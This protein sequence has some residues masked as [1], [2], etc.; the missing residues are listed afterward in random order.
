[1][2]KILFVGHLGPKITGAVAMN[3]EF[4]NAI[5]NSSHELLS[6]NISGTWIK[7]LGPIKEILKAKHVDFVIYTGNVKGLVIIKDWILTTVIKNFIKPKK[8]YYYSHSRGI[9]RNNQVYMWITQSIFRG[10]YPIILDETLK[11]DIIPITA[12]KP[13]KIL[14]N[15]S[16]LE[17]FYESNQNKGILFLSNFIQSKGVFDFLD[18]ILNLSNDIELGEIYMLGSFGYDINRIEIEEK[19]KQIN[20]KIIFIENPSFEQK[21]S[22][23]RNCNLLIFPSKYECQPL[24]ILEAMSL[25]LY[26]IAYNT[27]A[28]ENMLSNPLVGKCV[29]S[30]ESFQYEIEK[31]LKFPEHIIKNQ[32]RNVYQKNYDK[33]VF[34]SKVLELFN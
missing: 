1:M 18:F 15:F 2:A 22:A 26:T 31:A 34:Y 19:I 28:I 21:I 27:G 3:N 12:N 8:L 16:Q 4:C 10:I 33:G 24:V 25:G 11:F 6:I 9:S 14:S 32:I 20:G 5:N 17:K 13:Y 29:T 30:K 23:F 7:I